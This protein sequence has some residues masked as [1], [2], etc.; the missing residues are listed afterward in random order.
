M[1][2]FAYSSPAI[3]A[4]QH[5]IDLLHEL[6]TD[7]ASELYEVLHLSA[8]A[9]EELHNVQETICTVQREIETCPG[10]T[11]FQ[12]QWLAKANRRL[13]LLRDKTKRIGIAQKRLED[14]CFFL[15]RRLEGIELQ[16]NYHEGAIGQANRT[17]AVANGTPSSIKFVGPDKP[18]SG[19]RNGHVKNPNQV[20]Q[21]AKDREARGLGVSSGKKSKKSG[22]QDSKPQNARGK[23][24]RK[25]Q[26]MQAA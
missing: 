26:A 22:R 21:S 1:N 10:A 9:E 16:V 15:N 8:L 5:S 14:K 3:E 11:N 4:H 18:V 2:A 13:G 24:A 23:K 17:Q 7:T 6:A 25:Q 19:Q 12:Q 20:A